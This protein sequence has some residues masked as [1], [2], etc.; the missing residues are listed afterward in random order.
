MVNGV[1]RAPVDPPLHGVSVSELGNV[2]TAAIGQTSTG[3]DPS[4]AGI[5]TV[6]TMKMEAVRPIEASVTF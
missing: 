3:R 4:L 2:Q 6:Q 1:L 5:F